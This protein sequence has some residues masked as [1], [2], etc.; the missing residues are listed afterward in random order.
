MHSRGSM[1]TSD[2]ALRPCRD[3]KI[4]FIRLKKKDKKKKEKTVKY[5]YRYIYMKYY[6]Q[7]LSLIN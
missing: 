3:K 2:S 6:L 4:A 1:S 7:K 5:R